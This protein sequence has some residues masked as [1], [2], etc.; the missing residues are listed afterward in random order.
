MSQSEIVDSPPVMAMLDAVTELV[1]DHGHGQL[2]RCPDEQVVAGVDAA[3]RLAERLRAVGIG[4][5]AEVDRRGLGRQSGAVSSQAWLTG[6]Q[7]LRASHARR[8]LGL[9]RLIPADLDTSHPAGTADPADP[10]DATGDS[11]AVEGS[12][13]GR[14]LLGGL[15][16]VE[17]AGCIATA[18]AEL[19]EDLPVPVRVAVE[20]TLVT[21][22][23]VLRPEELTRFGHRVLERINPDA[24]DVRIAAQLAREE[25]EAARLRAGTR[26]DDGHGN[27]FYKLRVPVVDDAH[28]WAVLDALAQ[29][30]P[31]GADGLDPRTAR[32]RL[33]DAIVEAM[34]R[35][36][37]D[38]GLP[39]NGGD[40]A[41]AVITLS[42]DSLRSGL[43]VATNLDTGDLMTASAARRLAC[44]A[45]I[46]PA[47]LGGDGQVLDVGRARRTFDGPVRTAVITRDSGC[48]HPGCDRPARWCDVHHVTPWWDGGRTSLDNGVLL[49]GTHH[50]LYDA[51]T[52]TIRFAHDGIPECIPPPW[53][54]DA[55]TPVRH[56]RNH[57]RS[58]PAA[59]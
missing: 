29:P 53:V 48:I 31:S 32:Q 41:R 24:A 4:L 18:L 2:W 57:A 56:T 7:R 58:R 47:V 3:Y 50:R 40:R 44:D 1:D 12:A 26:Y 36:S 16:S 20:E 54:D 55:R 34:R 51:G 42:L 14:A 17:H 49:C 33:A 13:V 35:V 22:A 52:W 19:P 23:K 59:A 21:Q 45:Q 8:D 38:G 28:I 39:A 25:R 9:A 5:V 6:R 30:Q 43:G 10:T 27:V 37:L 11:V 15:I 46:S